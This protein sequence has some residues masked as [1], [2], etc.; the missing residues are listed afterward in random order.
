MKKIHYNK[1]IRD[2]VPSN[3][4]KKGVQFRVTTLTTEKTKRELLRKVGEE[5]SALPVVRDR[6]ELISELGDVL[7]VIDEIVR[8][9]KISH[10]DLQS[11]RGLAMKKKGGFRKRYYL[12]WSADNGYRTNERIGKSRKAGLEKK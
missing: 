3:M 8:V 6:S 9:N 7:D 10:S 12:H 2:R 11:A 4:K 1:L 5:A